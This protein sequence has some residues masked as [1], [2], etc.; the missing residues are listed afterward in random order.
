MAY[1]RPPY[2]PYN[3]ADPNQPYPL[4]FPPELPYAEDYSQQSL[5]YYQMNPYG[6]A[7]YPPDYPQRKDGYEYGRDYPAPRNAPLDY[8]DGTYNPICELTCRHGDVSRIS[9]SKF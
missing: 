7:P 1:N 3:D 5:Q 2:P 8:D 4:G 6:G 9:R